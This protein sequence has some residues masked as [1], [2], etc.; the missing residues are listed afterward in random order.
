MYKRYFEHTQST[1]QSAPFVLA[2]DWLQL[3]RRAT[4]PNSIY[5]RETEFFFNLRILPKT[6][7]NLSF[8]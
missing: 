3:I 1:N 4:F 5:T 7:S 2:S 6:K 8:N